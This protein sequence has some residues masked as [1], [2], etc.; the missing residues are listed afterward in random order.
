MLPQTWKTSIITVFVVL[1][2]IGESSEEKARHVWM[3]VAHT[4]KDPRFKLEVYAK[5]RGNNADFFPLL[6]YGLVADD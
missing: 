1:F 6:E 5:F 3:G 2:I 4:G